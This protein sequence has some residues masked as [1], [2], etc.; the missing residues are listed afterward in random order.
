MKPNTTID[1][2]PGAES[3][4]LKRSDAES[5]ALKRSDFV[6]D[7]KNLQLPDDA[8]KTEYAI[9]DELTFFN[10]SELKVALFFYHWQKQ[11]EMTTVKFIKMAKEKI[12][13][14][15]RQCYN[16]L[17]AAKLFHSED[18]LNLSMEH[19]AKCLTGVKKAEQLHR[20]LDMGK[21][22]LRAFLEKH[23]PSKM[24]DEM[25]EERVNAF[26]FNLLSDDARKALA[27]K[28]AVKDEA[29]ALETFKGALNVTG[30]Q[31]EQMVTAARKVG[32]E[33]CFM[34]GLMMM[35][36]AVDTGKETPKSIAPDTWLS[37]IEMIEAGLAE[38]KTM[39][40][41]AGVEV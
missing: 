30:M 24:T 21:N 12:Y 26:R 17:A 11:L 1:V 7:L 6:V 9:L 38:T 20:L 16:Y 40:K 10:T 3:T 25:V 19:K 18:F 36:A 31:Q 32:A 15:D 27:E 39:A 34:A 8:E 4:A 14:S 5:T 22:T 35:G 23:D 13:L 2:T 33:K 29:K 41:Q 37:W 28:N